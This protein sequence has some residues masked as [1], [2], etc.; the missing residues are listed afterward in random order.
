MF[1][2]YIHT[3]STFKGIVHQDT[4]VKLKTLSNSNKTPKPTIQGPQ[5]Y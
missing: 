1:I 5:A 4:V 3:Y 2:K